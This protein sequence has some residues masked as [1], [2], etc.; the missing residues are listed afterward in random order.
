VACQPDDVAPRPRDATPTA[1]RPSTPPPNRAKRSAQT[2]DGPADTQQTRSRTSVPAHAPK[3][4]SWAV[5]GILDRSSVVDHAAVGAV[6]NT[7]SAATPQAPQAVTMVDV[8]RRRRQRPT[9]RSIAGESFYR[10][11]CGVRSERKRR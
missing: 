4:L 8:R 9:R 3:F 6:R 5:S 7:L 1:R 11:D 10:A 2:L